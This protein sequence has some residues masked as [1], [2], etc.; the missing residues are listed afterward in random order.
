V[1]T[2]LRRHRMPLTLS[3]KEAPLRAIRPIGQVRPRFPQ[4]DP[5]HWIETGQPGRPFHFAHHMRRL[6]G[7]IVRRSSPLAHIDPDRLLYGAIQAR[8]GRTHGLQA[9]VTPLRCRHGRL[10]RVR[11]GVIYQVQRYF[12]GDHEYFYLVAFCLPRYLDRDFDDKLVTLFHELY[13]IGP[14]F[15]GDLRR[16]HGRCSMHSR[17]KKKYDVHMALL[18]RDYLAGK[19]DE[20]LLGFLRLDYAQLVRRHGS[21]MGICVPR[22]KLIPIGQER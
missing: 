7:D 8:T 17:S 19:P 16:H 20:A 13:H 9:R 18:A 1:T 6:V 2:L 21:V 12:I 5:P 10:T 14:H 15:D 4:L 22:P 3:W 11:K